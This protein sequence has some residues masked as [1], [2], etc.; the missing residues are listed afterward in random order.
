MLFNKVESYKKKI[1]KY[2][3]HGYFKDAIEFCRKLIDLEPRVKEHYVK[4]V[5]LLLSSRNR[6]QALKEIKSFAKKFPNEE[7]FIINYIKNTID[8]TKI[9]S[10][11]FIE[12][13]WKLFLEKRDFENLVREIQL[14]NP[15]I[16]NKFAEKYKAKSESIYSYLKNETEEEKNESF[17]LNLYLSAYLLK[18]QHQFEDYIGTLKQIYHHFPLEKN[19]IEE[20][21]DKVIRF[22]QNM[23]IQEDIGE[24]YIQNKNYNKGLK[25]VLSLVEQNKNY[26]RKAI[27]LL[28]PHDED[29]IVQ[30][31]L[32]KL[33][34]TKDNFEKAAD[35]YF[36]AYSKDPTLFD[37]LEKIFENLV[38]KSNRSSLIIQ[39]FIE[40]LKRTDNYEKTADY[41]HLLSQND[42][43]KAVN[44]RELLEKIIEKTDSEELKID[45]ALMEYYNGDYDKG[46]QLLFPILS[47]NEEL[48]EHV[49][50]KV[51]MLLDTLG[52][53]FELMTS[54]LNIMIILRDEEQ[55]SAAVED[56]INNFSDNERIKTL[57]SKIKEIEDKFSYSLEIMKSV[58][59]YYLKIEKITK[60]LDRIYEI[61]LHT[62]D[63]IL[64]FIP[65]FK[66]IEKQY[67]SHKKHILKILS[68]IDF[69]SVGIA[70]TNFILEMGKYLIEIGNIREGL[71]KF[72]EII[73]KESD[74][75]SIIAPFLEEHLEK[76][77]D[78]DLAFYL[79]KMLEKTNEL[80]LASAKAVLIMNNNILSPDIVFSKLKQYYSQVPDN[81]EV[82]RNFIIVLEKKHMWNELIKLSNK[83]L[84]LNSNLSDPEKII[85]YKK[86]TSAEI[87]VGNL[88]KAID[89][90]NLI[91]SI[92]DRENNFIKDTLH[93]ILEI[94]KNYSPAFESLFHIYYDEQEYSEALK[95]IHK[96]WSYNPEKTALVKSLLSTLEKENEYN[97]DLLFFKAKLFHSENNIDKELEVLDVIQKINEDE[98]EKVIRYITHLI[99]KGINNAE[100]FFMLGKL[101]LSKDLEK[102]IHYIDKAYNIDISKYEKIVYYLKKE[103]FVLNKPKEII[104]E[105]IKLFFIHKDFE[106]VMKYFG[107][108]LNKKTIEVDEKLQEI[109]IQTIRKINRVWDGYR[110]ILDIWQDNKCREEDLK[111]IL[112]ALRNN[113]P[114][115]LSEVINKIN[116]I[117]VSSE[118]NAE[119]LIEYL[120]ILLKTDENHKALEISSLLL[121][122]FK[123]KT[124]LVINLYES[125]LET[126]GYEKET[127]KNYIKILFYSG[128]KKKLDE[129]LENMIN[130]DRYDFQDVLYYLALKWEDQD[131]SKIKET[132][133]KIKNDGYNC[134]EIYHGLF[135]NIVGKKEYSLTSDKMIEIA[136]IYM[137]LKEY[138]KAIEI[139]K[140]NSTDTLELETDRLI[141]LSFCL[142]SIGNFSAAL[143]LMLILFNEHENDLSEQSRKKVYFDL[144]DTAKKTGNKKLGFL[145]VEKLI[146]L[147]LDETEDN[148]IFE[149]SKELSSKKIVSLLRY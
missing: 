63:N 19:H 9:E 96:I 104:I 31:V 127:V 48:A 84:S 132:V 130:E 101:Y 149:Y 7:I 75:V 98:K 116:N 145:V 74:A 131:V 61:L 115:K 125:I 99:Q 146:D 10:A 102:G 33:F 110:Y 133:I 60:A 12:F 92:S 89:Y 126:K 87:E 144:L 91:R 72:N 138:D 93:N 22:T 64:E 44:Y 143:D 40:M 20:E 69:D 54:I 27:K 119:I 94:K 120:D 141:K 17:L 4:L 106:N 139:L 129:Y 135:E 80:G 88:E 18:A 86:I 124:D 21:L 23:N 85:L 35:Y 56:I 13:V 51:S 49:L 68:Q 118:F 121:K 50:E 134:S 82:I 58:I 15:E 95:I 26:I 128:K 123:S 122:R 77:L 41:V 14:L 71:E 65:Y 62:P 66:N 55:I 16:M 45:L 28:E 90:L 83:F 25:Y 100:A 2:E 79:I 117:F 59:D 105:L 103:N 97:I 109:L 42:F 113:F 5:D 3:G 142:K 140:T 52:P 8:F 70:D 148:L 43:E 67:P 111:F 36:K 24:F 107:Q 73:D 114:E 136:D 1:A 37:K 32:G 34:Y 147:P 30:Q 81:P 76:N 108:L 46:D 39:K 29:I 38:K 78:K 57:S 53:K 11:N 6:T 112:N 47:K 137:E